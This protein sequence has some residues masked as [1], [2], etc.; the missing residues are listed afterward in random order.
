[1][2]A[3]AL[4]DLFAQYLPI[5]FLRLLLRLLLRFPTRQ[6]HEILSFGTKFKRSTPIGRTTRQ[7]RVI[8]GKLPDMQRAMRQRINSDRAPHCLAAA[9]RS[10]KRRLVDRPAEKFAVA[11]VA[12]RAEIPADTHTRGN[13]VAAEASLLLDIA[14]ARQIMKGTPLG[15]APARNGVRQAPAALLDN[16]IHVGS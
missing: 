2:L 14:A 9:S 16:V 13:G 5:G 11:C 4:L 3:Q 8:E 12:V 15:I 10:T 6:C 1:M 7:M